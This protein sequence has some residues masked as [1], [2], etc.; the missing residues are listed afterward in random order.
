HTP[1]HPSVPTRR[2]SD[3]GFTWGEQNKIDAVLRNLRTEA[4]SLGA[5]GVL[6]QGTAEGFGRSGVS[7]GAGGGRVSGRGFGSVGVGVDVSPDRKSTRL[8]SSH[9]KIS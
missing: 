2:S 3:L 4:A 7:V 6:F 9:V 8:N 1:P 5:N